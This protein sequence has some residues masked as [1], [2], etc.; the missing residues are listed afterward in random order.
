MKNLISPGVTTS[1][2]DLTA[3]AAESKTVRQRTS[4]TPVAIDAPAVVPVPIETVNWTTPVV[5]EGDLIGSTWTTGEYY[6]YRLDASD[7][8]S[9]I[10]KSAFNAG[11]G[12]SRIFRVQSETLC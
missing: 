2:I 8:L 10:F 6:G 3:K 9:A 5:H 11:T 7:D 1:I 12:L 4:A